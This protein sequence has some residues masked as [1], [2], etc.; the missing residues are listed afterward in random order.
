MKTINFVKHLH[1]H[2]CFLIREESNHSVFQNQLNKKISSVPRHR[3]VKKFLVKKICKDL[4]I[5]PP[6]NFQ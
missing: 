5:S 3:E 2:N 1:S 6:E 4:D